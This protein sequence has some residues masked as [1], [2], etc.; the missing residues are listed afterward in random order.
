MEKISE[1]LAKSYFICARQNSRGTIQPVDPRQGLLQSRTLAKGLRVVDG[2]VH[3]KKSFIIFLSKWVIL[4]KTMSR[5]SWFLTPK[6]HSISTSKC[7]NKKEFYALVIRYFV[8]SLYLF[9]KTE[10]GIE[11]WNRNYTFINNYVV[12]VLF[13]ILGLFSECWGWPTETIV[14]GHARVKHI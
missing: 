4:L 11:N 10:W 9:L 12:F 2:L 7:L 14:C 3:S 6:Y 5:F 13:M 8:I 1:N